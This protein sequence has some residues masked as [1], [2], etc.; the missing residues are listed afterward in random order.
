MADETSSVASTVV[1][2]G[3]REAGAHDLL[4]LHGSSP[5]QDPAQSD[6]PWEA[7]DCF[8]R[9]AENHPILAR[10]AR[11]MR[12]VRQAREEQTPLP[13]KKHR[14]VAKCLSNEDAVM[15]DLQLL[16]LQADL[17]ARLQRLASLA[18]AAKRREAEHVAAGP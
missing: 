15:V 11:L 10:A 12:E 13:A 17:D 2:G 8:K 14:C 4:R 18:Q 16:A 1:M 6:V 5:P 3:E 7:Q 9:V